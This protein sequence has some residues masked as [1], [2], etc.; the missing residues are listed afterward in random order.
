MA[1][2]SVND[3]SGPSP[4][5]AAWVRDTFQAEQ[6]K[7]VPYTPY[8]T[9]FY[10]TLQR[11]ARFDDAP[12]QTVVRPDDTA[13]VAAILR[14]ANELAE[15]V[16]VRQGTGLLSLDTVVPFPP[17]A[18]VVDLRRLDAIR[19]HPESGYVEVGPA[20]TLGKTNA[21]LD[22]L[23]FQF[24]IA[25]QNVQ[26]GGL[27]SINLS[28]HLVDAD[29]GKPGDFVLGLTVVLPDGTVLETGTKSMRKVVGP[30][31]TRLFIGN[32]ALLGVITELRLRLRPKPDARVYAWASFED[33]HGIADT[34][35]EMYRAGL[36]YPA[37][38][39][40]VESTFV[41]TS[42]MGALVPEGHLLMISTEGADA[43]AAQQKATALL[44]LARGNG[45]FDTTTVDD[46]EE[47]NRLWD[48]RENPF[49]HMGP[50]EFLLGEA[51]DVP[52]QRMH[53]GLDQVQ[54]LLREA[55]SDG[56][57]G[58]LVSHIGAG[59]LHPM[60]ACPPE[61]DYDRR[62]AVSRQLRGSILAC[63]AELDATVGE[64]GIYPQHALWFEQAY[65]AAAASLLR[66]LKAAVDPNDILNRG[67]IDAAQLQGS[68]G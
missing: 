49:R 11:P 54:A 29:A 6:I 23:G 53:E 14:R 27:V 20:V 40:L 60:F 21:V 52:L 44:E 43:A 41:Q 4:Q 48:I 51:L 12:R 1:D 50:E 19:P 17:G 7:R 38:M 35:I 58:Y 10:P 8:L 39:E 32:Q 34:V 68:N 63:K 9:F 47:W 15:P 26:W 3:Q 2:H 25:V 64:Q 59:T 62:V 37:V 31:L 30:D 65:G 5:L 36:A 57:R 22:G 13:Q 42:G 55:E 46:E 28:G 67:R 16:Y 18:V 45:A 61:W 24:P 56:L 33:I 66:R